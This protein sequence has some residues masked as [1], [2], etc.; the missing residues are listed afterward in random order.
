MN[1]KKVIYYDINLY[2]IKKHREEVNTMELNINVQERGVSW[3][4]INKNACEL[5]SLYDICSWAEMD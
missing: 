1:L 3:N 5:A 2:N 4:E